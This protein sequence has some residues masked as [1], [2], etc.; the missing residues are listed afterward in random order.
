M[1]GDDAELTE[2]YKVA[3]YDKRLTAETET[4]VTQKT[5]KSSP[6]TSNVVAPKTGDETPFGLIVALVGA[7]LLV[8]ALLQF[9]K[10]RLKD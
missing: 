1:M 8:A 5:Q 10:T 7:G 6:S 9:W 2:S 3:L 4:V